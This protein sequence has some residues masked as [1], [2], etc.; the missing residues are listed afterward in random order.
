MEKIEEKVYCQAC[1]RETNHG[2]IQSFEQNGSDV[3]GGWYEKYH[4]AQC[5]GC[6]R[7][8]FVNESWDTNMHYYDHE[9]GEFVEFSVFK[10]YPEKP[11]EP[12]GLRNKITVREFMKVPEFLS[13]LYTHVVGARNIRSLILAGAGLRMIV[14]GICKDQG[15]A[16]GPVYDEAG[17]KQLQGDGSEKRVKNL[18]G[19]INGLVEKGFVT[20]RQSKILHQI[21]EL[22]NYTVHEVQTPKLATIT[23]GIEVIEHIF[24]TIYEIDG[25][26]ISPKKK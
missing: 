19:K 6:D 2:I 5:L 21:R 11:D 22:G 24:H 10:V 18:I 16:D 3:G 15:I 23:T 20:F 13:E 7:I 9:I 25:Y 26:K 8:A 12:E 4:I 1:K 17:E 14:E